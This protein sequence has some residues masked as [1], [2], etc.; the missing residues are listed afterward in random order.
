VAD[1]PV[2]YGPVVDPGAT[3]A[4][5]GAADVGPPTDGHV[6]LF[7]VE[8]FYTETLT[9]LSGG[10]MSEEYEAVISDEALNGSDSTES[11]VDL[12]DGVTDG[13][14]NT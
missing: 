4:Q 9:T 10:P 8:L 11:D 3:S 2:P 14:S 5:H 13:T 1:T 7:Y 12:G 6:E